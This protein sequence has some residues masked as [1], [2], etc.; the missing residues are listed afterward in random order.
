MLN[1]RLLMNVVTAT[2][3]VFVMPVTSWVDG[4]PNLTFS[5][6]NPALASFPKPTQSNFSYVPPIRGMPRRTQGTG[7]RGC[8][9]SQVA[10]QLLVPNDHTAETSSGHPTFFWYISELP[11]EP[12]EFALVESGVAQPIFVK[13]LQL[14]K[15]GIVQLEMPKNLPE[16]LPNREYRWSVSL[17][18]N[19]LRHSNDS[20]A[21]GW[22]K[23]VPVTPLLEQQLAA[24]KSD[25]DSPAETLRERASVYAKAGLWYDA[26]GAIATAQATN[27]SDPSIREDFLSLLAQVGLKEVALQEQQRLARH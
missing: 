8:E 25:R 20:F 24:A 23:R 4:I 14:N 21:Q 3:S 19:A 12:V 22:I 27:S 18:C 26:L 17:I 7:T 11:K 6:T 13:Q 2:A 9:H 15:T 10:L 16:L 1:S 5:T